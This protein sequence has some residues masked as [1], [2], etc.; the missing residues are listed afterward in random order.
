MFWDILEIEPTTDTKKI[1]MAYREKLVDSNPEEKP[2]QFKVLRE[3]YEKAMEYARNDGTVQITPVQLWQQQLSE[4]YHDFRKRINLNCWQQLFDQPVCRSI[5]TRS[6]IEET[7]LNF[8]MEFY[9]LPKEV[10]V[11][12]N[13]EF[14]FLNRLEELYEN[15]DRDFIDYIIVNG[16]NYEPTLKYEYFYPGENGEEV[17]E[18]FRTFFRIRKSD[19]NYEEN[20]AHLKQLSEQH[21]YGDIQIMLDDTYKGTDRLVE[22]IALNMKYDFD[23]YMSRILANELFDRKMY[24]EVEELC[25]QSEEINGKD[26]GISWLLAQALSFEEKYSEAVD[27]IQDLLRAD[28][29]NEARLEDITKLRTYCNDRLIEDFEKK[30][31]ENPYDSKMNVSYAWALLQNN[32]FEEAAEIAKNVREEDVDEFTYYN[33]KSS[34][35][36]VQNDEKGI[37]T[38]DRLVNIIENMEDDGTEETRKRKGRVAEMISRKAYLLCMLDR[39]DEGI[40]AYNEALKRNPQD[41]E[42]LM[43]LGNLCYNYKRYD[44]AIKWCRELIRIKPDSFYAYLIMAESYFKQGDDS[45]AFECVNR[46]ISLYGGSLESYIVKLRILIRNDAYEAAEELLAFLQENNCGDYADVLFCKANLLEFEKDQKEEAKEIYKEVMARIDEGEECTV[47]AETCYRYLYLIGLDRNANIEDE[48]N[49]MIEIADRGLKIN[50]D[51]YGLVDYKAWLLM[52]SGKFEES[53]QLYRKLE[54]YPNHSPEVEYEIGLYYYNQH[55][56][57]QGDR[58]IEYLQKALDKGYEYG[59]YELTYA[60]YAANRLQEAK[61]SCLKL[62]ER[63]DREG[64][65]DVDSYHRMSYIYQKEKKYEQA[66]VEAVQALANALKR[67]IKKERYF[68]HVAQL[69]KIMGQPEKAVEVIQQMAETI[70]DSTAERELVRVYMQFGMYEKAREIVNRKLDTAEGCNDSIQLDFLQNRMSFAKRTLV[71]KKGVMNEKDIYTSC[72]HIYE[73]DGRYDELLKLRLQEYEKDRENARAHDLVEIAEAY[74]MVDDEENAVKYGQ[75]ALEKLEEN[76]KIYSPF[77]T[78]D[79]VTLVRIY[80][81]LKRF[82]EA[83]ELLKMARNNLCEHCS[84]CGC[85]D[86]DLFELMLLQRQHRYEEAE[87]LCEQSIEKWKDDADFM[88]EREIIRKRSRK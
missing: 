73:F 84:Y 57:Q 63:A 6:Q 30:Y 21:P 85:K 82:D 35:Y 75:M 39:I 36:F 50:A 16:I 47:G 15:Y 22:M 51:H 68:L 37:E 83:E 23:H 80:T 58:A 10:L 27:Q 31:A 11:F 64:Y 43:E 53:L 74:L 4:I 59:Q 70:E 41:S 62:R 77:R 45:N 79:D 86:A 60:L 49:E 34:V 72:C 7:L 13:E 67:D 25:R 44:E 56:D 87:R 19:E 18:Y 55:L 9:F 28:T 42:V 61:Q 78:L 54:E 14:D 76:R 32:R 29:E 2:E 88:S 52:K 46:S 26:R 69:Y 48:R 1:T 65:I 20:L 5:D 8:M 17:D 24:A 3:A 71:E 33:L 40:S 12:L 38:L 66:L 81:V